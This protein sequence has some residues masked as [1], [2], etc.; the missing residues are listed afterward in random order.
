MTGDAR[1]TG[2]V[3]GFTVFRSTQ[4]TCY[5]TPVAPLGLYWKTQ[6]KHDTSGD[7]SYYANL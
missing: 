7:L 6:L 4:P 1:A 2:M 3:L 5:G